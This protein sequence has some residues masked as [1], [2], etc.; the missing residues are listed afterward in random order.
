MA[1][2]YEGEKYLPHNSTSDSSSKSE[3]HYKHKSLREEQ[4]AS[5]WKQNA[6]DWIWNFKTNEVGT[7]G[8]QNQKATMGWT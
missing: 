8:W 5:V 4:T 7:L 1:V 2:V 6:A 3:N